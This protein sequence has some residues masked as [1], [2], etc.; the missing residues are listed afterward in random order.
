MTFFKACQSARANY[1][2]LIANGSLV[3]QAITNFATATGLSF[4]MI[5]TPG[6]NNLTLPSSTVLGQAIGYLSDVG[7]DTLMTA[8]IDTN[9]KQSN[10]SKPYKFFI[11]QPTLF[12]PLTYY[13]DGAWASYTRANYRS[14]I[15]DLF[16]RQVS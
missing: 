2:S 10:G 1:A 7:V 3:V 12:Y 15:V 14:T 5:E 13:S 11:D 9:W 6:A 16:R 4:S 8:F